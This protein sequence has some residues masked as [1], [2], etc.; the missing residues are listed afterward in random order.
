MKLRPCRGCRETLVVGRGVRYCALCQ[1]RQCLECSRRGGHHRET[2]S[3]REARLCRL[4]HA[5]VFGENGHRLAGYDDV[6]DGRSLRYCAACRKKP[7]CY[8]CEHIEGTGHSASCPVPLRGRR[9]VLPYQGLIS[10]H[11]FVAVYTANYA[12][13]VATIRRVC[14]ADAEDVV[15]TVAVYF[16]RRLDTLT[17]LEADL[18]FKAV[19]H[20]AVKVG[21]RSA[22]RRHV[23][24][25]DDLVAAEHRQV[26]RARG[27]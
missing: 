5:P 16:W 26:R 2:C 3:R 27:W 10:E 19:W 1:Q 22:W 13:A 12:K 20:Q 11:D 15:Q 9:P 4:C 7:R 18:F 25:S 8:H 6:V 14:G 24:L 23:V 17:H 21:R